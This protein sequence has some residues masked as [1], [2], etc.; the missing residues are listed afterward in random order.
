MRC[1]D[2]NKF[3]AFDDGNVDEVEV[4]LDED[5]GTVGIS[6]RVVLP[7]AECGTELKELGVDDSIEA[8]DDFEPSVPDAVRAAVPES[9]RA[10]A[11]DEWVEKNAKVRYEWEGGDADKE[12][13]ERQQSTYVVRKGKDKGKTK[14]LKGPSR[15]RKTYKGVTVTGTVKRTITFTV[16][17]SPGTEIDDTHDV[18]H[19][20]EEQASGFDELT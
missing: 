11:T 8:G 17:G 12:F 20:V 14:P 18:E 15:F 6:G 10:T 13:S 2:C 16:P 19:T 1:P 3:V 4:E 5:T 9:F 7:C